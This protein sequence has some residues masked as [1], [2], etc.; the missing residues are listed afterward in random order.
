MWLWGRLSEPTVSCNVDKYNMG[1]KQ[2]YVPK[3]YLKHFEGKKKRINMF[4]INGE[5]F[6]PD[7]GLRDQCYNDFMYGSD[8]NLEEALAN[9]ESVVAPILQQCVNEGRLPRS[10]SEEM[11]MLGTV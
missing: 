4:Y 2:H 3:F 11:D 1:K 6:I 5:R 9:F 7:V 10:G 8:G